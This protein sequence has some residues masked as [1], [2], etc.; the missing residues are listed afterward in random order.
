MDHLSLTANFPTGRRD[1]TRSPPRQVFHDDSRGRD[2]RYQGDDMRNQRDYDGHHGQGDQGYSNRGGAS[3][4]Y[5]Q[6]EH[7]YGGMYDE[8]YQGEGDYARDRYGDESYQ[9][10]RSRHR[11]GDDR[12]SRSRSGS[13][14]H[15]VTREA[16]KPSDT[17]ILEGLPFNVSSSE[18]RESILKNSVA[19]E[20]PSIDVR[21]T[22]SRGHCRAFVQFPEVDHAVIFMR[23]HYP[24]I[25]LE[26]AHPTDDVPD[27][28]FDAYIHYARSRETRE[29]VDPRAAGGSN[30]ICSTCDFSNYSTRIK[31]KICG[32]PQTTPNW[33]QNLTGVTDAADVPSQILVVYPLPPFVNEDMFINDIK[34]LEVEKVDNA[35]DNSNGAPKLKSTAPTGDTSRYG[36]RPGSLHRV[37][38]MRDT[39]TDESFKYGFVEFWTLEDAAAAVA[40]FQKSRSFMVA[41]CP[42]TVSTIHMGVFV[43]EERQVT[44]VIERMSF[45]P[46]FNPSLRVRYR[47][48]HVYPSQQIVTSQPPGGS[49]AAKSA[50]DEAG[51]GK[52][53][54]KRK[55]EGTPAGA[56]TKKL[57]PMAGQ[58]AMWQRK[59]GELRGD[60]R[61]P[62]DNGSQNAGG[63]D[64][65]RAPVRISL[66]GNGSSADTKPQG[67]I[68]ISLSGATKLGAPQDTSVRKS[69]TPEPTAASD[70]KP[71]P[72]PDSDNATVS[73]VDRDRLMCLICMRKYKSV[74]EVNIHEKSR[75]HKNATENEEQVKAALP[76]LAA[77]DKRLQKQAQENP[78]ETHATSQYRDRAKERRQVYNQPVK[79]TPTP[80]HQTKSKPKQPPKQEEVAQSAKPAQSKGAGMLAKM[81]WSAGAGLG[82][83]GDGR[84][85]AIATNAYQGGVGLGAEGGNLGDAAQ[86]AERKTKNSYT[87][88]LNTVQDK[89]RERY[90]KMD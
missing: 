61:G 15:S 28:K 4:G 46:L 10:E 32:G 84:T 31:C 90:N 85:E 60:G 56:S 41:A 19:A 48:L 35:K 65:D 17:V 9:R 62:S 89:A 83:N 58:M 16:G 38:L 74:D 14:S 63:D 39:N 64:Q 5:A 18:L 3:R 88:Y 33:Q 78:D 77:R 45:N 11:D 24:K 50:T 68:K 87:D 29:D 21:V 1:Q 8:G 13:R 52:K 40:K 72:Q 55:A 69:S 34:R 47:D 66:S 80:G 75:N 79:P 42:V 59:R 86:L 53:S 30:W 43:P 67:P 73:Y 81:G 20:L 54:K 44:P 6:D 51:D 7:D 26:L 12:I 76:R 27:G 22:A 37:F 57:V 70:N 25:Y 49:D 71:Q 82:A 36:A 23:E 2:S